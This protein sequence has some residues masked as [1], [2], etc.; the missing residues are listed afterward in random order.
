VLALERFLLV[1]PP[2]AVKQVARVCAL[3]LAQGDLSKR[4][5]TAKADP[6]LKETLSKSIPT[7]NTRPPAEADPQAGERRADDDHN[8]AFGT[9]GWARQG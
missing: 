8:K 6:Q 1:L 4:R 3:P 7:S 9:A 2:G 5:P